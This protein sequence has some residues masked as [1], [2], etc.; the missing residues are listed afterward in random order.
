MPHDDLPNRDNPFDPGEDDA[1]SAEPPRDGVRWDEQ[2]AGGQEPAAPEPDLEDPFE[3]GDQPAPIPAEPERPDRPTAE[4]NNGESGTGAREVFRLKREGKLAEAG[5]LAR[6]L[7]AESPADPWVI[8]ALFYVLYDLYKQTPEPEREQIRQELL[9]LPEMEDDEIYASIRRK[10][11]DE[12]QRAVWKARDLDQQGRPMEAKQALEEA[13]RRFPGDPSLERALAWQVYGVLKWLGQQGH[14]GQAELVG[15][16]RPLLKLTTVE[17]PQLFDAL[18]RLLVT[19]AREGR[20]PGFAS[21]VMHWEV[22]RRLRPEHFRPSEYQGNTVPPLAERILGALRR[23]VG[24]KTSPTIRDWLAGFSLR[25]GEKVEGGQ[26]APYHVG[27]ILVAIGRPEEARRWLRPVVRK[28]ASE[29][30]AWQALAETYPRGSAERLA[31]L[32]RAS[33]CPFGNEE[34]A[35]GVL[36]DF[37][38]ALRA[39]GHLAEARW[40]FEKVRSIRLKQGWPTHEIDEIL[41]CG[42]LAVVQPAECAPL[43]RRLAEC[44][45]DLVWEDV[46][47]AQGWIVSGPFQNKEGKERRAL[48]LHGPQGTSAVASRTAFGQLWDSPV[49]TPVRV[50]IETDGDHVRVI[51]VRPADGG[52]WE[53]WPTER[54]VLSD[55]NR[56]KRLAVFLRESGRVAVL[57]F[58]ARPGIERERPGTFWTVRARSRPQGA[59]QVV[60]LEPCDDRSN[61][62]AWRTME[63]Y[64]RLA[65]NRGHG[66]VGEAHVP[67]RLLQESGMADQDGALVQVLAVRSDPS[68]GQRP[69]RAVRIDRWDP[70]A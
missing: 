64:L 45:D 70:F 5:V 17:D 13:L 59:D 48:Q 37:G 26:W 23:A 20:F 57:G 58:D 53:G 56:D 67:A 31:L 38:M 7:Y 16:L 30:W 69:W 15:Q 60:D 2:P 10:L 8:R 11:G 1:A 65:P 66:T 50:R 22:E 34:Y 3:D 35:V 32:A 4:P 24:E 19:E 27:K 49:G 68:H 12:V 42:D 54:A 62:D 47:L 18:M 46:P 33:L 51:Q 36:A 6:R 21:F 25:V 14:L 9:A 39:E 44:A 55:H 29:G 52:L 61:S 28:K 41:N 63:E 40:M 43:S